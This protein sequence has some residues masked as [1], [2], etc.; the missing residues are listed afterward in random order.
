MDEQY[1]IQKLKEGA[2]FTAS[3]SGYDTGR[4]KN[5]DGKIYTYEY[6]HKNGFYPADKYP[7]KNGWVLCDHTFETLAKVI[8]KLFEN[9]G[10]AIKMSI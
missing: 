7:L 5:I 1:I 9:D 3:K 2:V 8:K 4:W 6:Y 10:W